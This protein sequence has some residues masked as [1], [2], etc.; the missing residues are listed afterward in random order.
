MSINIQNNNQ[1]KIIVN[2]S[3]N[4]NL[5]IVNGTKSSAYLEIN[6]GKNNSIS[7]INESEKSESTDIDFFIPTIF[8]FVLIFIIFLILRKNKNN[9]KKETIKE[10]EF[11]KIKKELNFI[12]DNKINSENIKKRI[13]SIINDLEETYK[14]N[15]E[16]INNLKYNEKSLQKLENENNNILNK[17][18]DILNKL[19][20]DNSKFNLSNLDEILRYV[21]LVQE[22]RKNY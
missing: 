16:L 17:L 15:V 10:N 2:N 9:I 1:A 3:E 12:I 14:K 21:N 7:M 11:M 8:L 20:I 22:T 18:K 19:E 5:N 13:N 6:E 4:L